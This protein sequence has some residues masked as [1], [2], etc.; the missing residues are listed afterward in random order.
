MVIRD[1]FLSERFVVGFESGIV[2]IGCRFNGLINKLFGFL[3]F[4]R[5]L[6]CHIIFYSYIALLI[7]D[8]GEYIITISIN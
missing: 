3:V 1:K 2:F 6:W 4:L 5:N 7:R 8:I